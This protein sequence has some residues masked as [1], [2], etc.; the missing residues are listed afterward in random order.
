MI[1]SNLDDKFFSLYFNFGFF[2]FLTSFRVLCCSSTNLRDKVL[3]FECYGIKHTEKN[4]F[5]FIDND[6]G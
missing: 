4:I 6:K 2:F 5:S 3:S 1:T